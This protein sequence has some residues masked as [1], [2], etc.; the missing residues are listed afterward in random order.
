ML[1]KTGLIAQI[2][3]YFP[4]LTEKEI[5]IAV[6][7]ILSQIQQ[8]LISKKRV[9]IRDFGSFDL[10]YRAARISHNPRTLKKISVPEKYAVHF[11]CGKELKEKVNANQHLPIQKQD[12]FKKDNR[13]KTK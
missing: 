10:R 13:D 3:R 8:S 4:D 2:S 11:K 9:E 5:V 6:N 1:T 12:K 7:L